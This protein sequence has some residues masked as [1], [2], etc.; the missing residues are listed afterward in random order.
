MNHHDEFCQFIKLQNWMSPEFQ[1]ILILKVQAAMQDAYSRGQEN[2]RANIPV[3]DV[4]DQT[5]VSPEV[6]AHFKDYP[7]IAKLPVK[8]V[9]VIRRVLR[10]GQFIEAI[11]MCREMSPCSLLHAKKFVER[12]RAGEDGN[13]IKREYSE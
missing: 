9:A 4:Y 6:L 8:Q 12:M 5:P 11:K 3:R 10:K 7:S 13:K 2:P 1:H